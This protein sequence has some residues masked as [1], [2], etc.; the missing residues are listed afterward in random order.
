MASHQ[1]A[2]L[3]QLGE[4]T[5]ACGP[6][7]ALAARTVVSRWL[8]ACG[9]AE[10][11]DDACLLI[12]ELVTNSVLHAGQSRGAPLRIATFAV[13]GLVRVEV[14]DSGR[15]TVRRRAPDPRSG[16]F[17]LELVELIAARWG[18]SQEHGTRV[19]FELAARGPGAL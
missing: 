12:S 4:A 11:N 15:G 14:E 17:G 18:V 10:L 3:V 16:G 6:E 13:N 9:H 2:G 8:D 19:W 7:A 5:V 1:P